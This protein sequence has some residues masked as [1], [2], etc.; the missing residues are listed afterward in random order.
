MFRKKR[1]RNLTLSSVKDDYLDLPI[2]PAYLTSMLSLEKFFAGT[3]L[4]PQV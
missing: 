3:V 1:R 2:N 4:L